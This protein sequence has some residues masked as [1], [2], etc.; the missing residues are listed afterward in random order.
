MD[1]SSK[2]DPDEV[3]KKMQDYIAYIIAN[4][5]PPTPPCKEEEH[6]WHLDYISGRRG[7]VFSCKKCGKQK[8][9]GDYSFWP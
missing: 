9:D 1:S 6:D 7:H 5:S 2:P 8:D 4:P 3:L